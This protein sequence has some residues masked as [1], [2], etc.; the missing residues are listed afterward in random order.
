MP[1]K[2]FL[3]C[4]AIM[5]CFSYSFY[6]K[7]KTTFTLSEIIFLLFLALIESIFFSYFQLHPFCWLLA[8]L[9]LNISLF[10]F[11]S[12]SYSQKIT[13][14]FSADILYLLTLLFYDIL[15]QYLGFSILVFHYKALGIAIL[16]SIITFIFLRCH[17]LIDLLKQAKKEI[18]LAMS[19]ILILEILWLIFLLRLFPDSLYPLVILSLCF[20]FV[21]L[22]LFFHLI[23]EWQKDHYLANLTLRNNEVYEKIL[24]ENYKVRELRHDMKNTLVIL[25]QLT[26]QDKK[27]ECLQYIS[28]MIQVNEKKYVSSGNIGIDAIINDKIAANKEICFITSVHIKG[29]LLDPKD[30]AILLGN[31]LDNAIEAVKNEQKKE[32]KITILE[33]EDVHILIS[34]PC[35]QKLNIKKG[36][37]ISKKKDPFYHGIGRTS[38]QNIIHKYHGTMSYQH[39]NYEFILSISLNRCNDNNKT[40]RALNLNE[41]P[42]PKNR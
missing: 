7:E 22:Y 14:L 39:E 26:K 41:Q 24:Q 30:I 9:I 10:L 31:A 15:L 8:M 38:M 5:L 32:I 4:A 11:Y 34:N 3:L 23:L 28:E 33:E 13:M 42:H 27:E 25:Y 36:L 19:V 20:L 12:T 35:H 6:I 29:D 17:T 37:F 18:W 16:F 21:L 2:L 40:K 1:D